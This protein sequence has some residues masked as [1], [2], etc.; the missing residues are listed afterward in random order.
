[1][2][3]SIQKLVVTACWSLLLLPRAGA[4]SL[5]SLM[6]LMDS[7]HAPKS[8]LVVSL[9][10]GNQPYSFITRTRN[11]TTIGYSTKTFLTPSIAYYHK[12]GLGLS[13]STYTLLD[14]SQKGLFEYDITPSYDYV[15]DD[16]RV[17]V[18]FT[19]YLFEDT[20]K[21][22]FPKTPL[23]NE[24]YA[25]ITLQQLWVQ[26]SI[27][28]D[29]AFGAYEETGGIGNQFKRKYEAND[30]SVVTTLRHTFSFFGVLS[31]VDAV[32]IV[33]GVLLIMG[34]DKYNRSFGGTFYDARI[35][36]YRRV[37]GASSQTSA[38]DFRVFGASLNLS[39][40][41]GK[42]TISPQYFLDVPL[43]K[44]DR[45]HYSYFLTTVCFFF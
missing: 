36:R 14:G 3:K 22:P 37:Q 7:T 40:S 18:A 42:L 19:K 13:F 33:P 28:F 30:F 21:L 1:M 44:S 9:G 27:A 5:E 34:T 11:T 23:T 10:I 4:Q 39:Y 15:E 16:F 29:Y 2:T 45:S 26:P 35:R 38:F 25:Y 20:S 17:G 31:N 32:D 43:Q 8:E 24:L 6:M 12:S 41:I